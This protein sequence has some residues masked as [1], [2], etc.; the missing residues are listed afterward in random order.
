LSKSIRSLLYYLM[1][2][3]SSE[4]RQRQKKEPQV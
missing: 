3:S 4:W 2:L 1:I